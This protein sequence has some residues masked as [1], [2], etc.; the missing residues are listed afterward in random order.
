MRFKMATRIQSWPLK[1]R[2]AFKEAL[3]YSQQLKKTDLRV[4]TDATLTNW[5]CYQCCH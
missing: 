4:T 2:L 1:F 3:K 5:S